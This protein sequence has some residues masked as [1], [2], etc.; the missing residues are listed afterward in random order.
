MNIL[1]VRVTEKVD[2]DQK[3]LHLVG[4]LIRIIARQDNIIRIGNQFNMIIFQRL[5]RRLDFHGM[6]RITV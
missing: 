1:Q 5:K 2:L 3:W 6:M 4:M